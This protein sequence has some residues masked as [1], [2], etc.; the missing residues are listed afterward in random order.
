MFSAGTVRARRVR[1]GIIGAAMV[2]ASV[3]GVAPALAGAADTPQPNAEPFVDVSAGSVDLARAQ[4][5]A[6]AA[7]GP[8]TSRGLSFNRVA[9]RSVLAGAPDNSRGT[10]SLTID[11]PA[12]DGSTM[13]FNVWES[14][15]MAPELAAAFPE[16]T[17]YS[18][19]GIDDP[20]A[21]IVFD[22]TPH[23]FHAQVLSPTGAWYIDPAAMG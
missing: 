21:T 19:Q 14:A 23:G 5:G 2:L 17:T 10:G 6:A 11:L 15:I 16:I 20:A 12:P 9:M 4:A 22:V 18:G 13:S 8:D 7:S 3:V 1:N